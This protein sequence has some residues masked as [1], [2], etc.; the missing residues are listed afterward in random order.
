MKLA[1]LVL[2][3]STTF[4][5]ANHGHDT[6]K[7]PT[8]D[9]RKCLKTPDMAKEMKSYGEKYVF[10]GV[11]RGNKATVRVYLSSNKAWT[12]VR[13]Y[14]NGWSCMEAHGFFG[15]VLDRATPT[16]LEN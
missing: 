15:E 5:F 11:T 8:R 16:S 9:R 2:I 3:L 13:S 14:P 12:F 1:A 10:S 4:A 7:A 6:S